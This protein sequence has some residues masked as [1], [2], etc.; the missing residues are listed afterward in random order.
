MIHFVK[1]IKIYTA[2]K[3]MKAQL[4]SNV[5]HEN[6]KF[7]Q[8]DFVHTPLVYSVHHVFEKLTIHRGPMFNKSKNF[9]NA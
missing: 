5:N 8:I 7:G 9:I 2:Q 1:E 4:M 3:R 6:K